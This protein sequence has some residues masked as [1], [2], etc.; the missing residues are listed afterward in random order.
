MKMTVKEPGYG[1]R[2]TQQEL[3]LLYATKYNSQ[4]IPE[5]YERLMLDCINGDQQ[6][7]VRRDELKYVVP[8]SAYS[9]RP[10]PYDLFVRYQVAMNSGLHGPSSHH[11]YTT[12]MLGAFRLSHTNMALAVRWRLTS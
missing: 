4:D 1:V 11:F 9:L 7:F 12:S 8:Q 6:H 2:I 5:A 3:E 10:V